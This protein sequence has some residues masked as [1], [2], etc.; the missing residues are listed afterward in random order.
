MYGSLSLAK[1]TR[2][3]SL[4]AAPC[5]RQALFTVDIDTF[6]IP[7]FEVIS[8]VLFG[9]FQQLPVFVPPRN[10]ISDVVVSY[11]RGQPRFKA[12]SE[13]KLSGILG[14]ISIRFASICRTMRL[15]G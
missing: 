11:A 9:I 10:K 15:S 5:L 13:E 8:R 2:T 14:S 6:G 7:S 4:M 12:A 1:I 3:C